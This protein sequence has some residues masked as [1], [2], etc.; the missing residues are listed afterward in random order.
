M[1]F[2]HRT[3]AAVVGRREGHE[4][5]DGRRALAEHRRDFADGRDAWGGTGDGTMNTDVSGR[6]SP[7]SVSDADAQGSASGLQKVRWQWEHRTGFRD[8]SVANSE[9]IEEAYQRGDT[10]VHLKSGKRNGIPMELFLLDMLQHDPTTGNTRPIQRVGPKGFLH[11]LRLR[12]AQVIRRLETGKAPQRFEGKQRSQSRRESEPPPQKV[13]CVQRLCGKI[14]RSQ[15]FSIASMLVVLFNACWI[16]VDV[17]LNDKPLLLQADVPFQVAENLFCVAFTME[18]LVR[19]GAFRRRQDLFADYWFLLDATLVVMMIAETWAL[20]LYMLLRGSDGFDDFGQF[21][22]LRVVRLLRLPRLARLFRFFPELGTL[23]KGILHAM[24]SVAYTMIMLLTVIFVFGVIF[25]VQAEMSPNL[26]GLFPT[27]A[28]TMTVLLL[29]GTL[30]D[31]PGAVYDKIASDSPLLAGLFLLFIFLS[32]FTVLN[33]LIGILCEVVSSVSH[34]EKEDA[35]VDYLKTHLVE[36]FEC[37][38]MDDDRLLESKEFDL[39]ARNPDFRMVLARFGVNANDVI[40]LRDFLFADKCTND[41][42]D[43]SDELDLSLEFMNTKKKLSFDEIM[44]AILRLRGGN[45]AT[46]S[47]IVE[48]RMYVARCFE[49]LT[50][51]LP[52]KAATLRKSPR[53]G[54]HDGQE[55][56]IPPELQVTAFPSDLR[57]QKPVDQTVA[58]ALKQ[59]PPRGREAVA[60]KTNSVTDELLLTL[61]PG[62][63]GAERVSSSPPW[64]GESGPQQ[65]CLDAARLPPALAGAPPP[66]WEPLPPC[67]RHEASVP[68]GMAAAKVGV[69]APMH[70][71]SP[72]DFLA[73]SAA[74]LGPPMAESGEVTPQAGELR[75]EGPLEAPLEVTGCSEPCSPCSA[76]ARPAAQTGQCGDHASIELIGAR[77]P[78]EVDASAAQETDEPHEFFVTPTAPGVG[79][80]IALH[81]KMLVGMLQIYVEPFLHCGDEAVERVLDLDASGQS[82]VATASAESAA[83]SAL[84][85]GFSDCGSHKIVISVGAPRYE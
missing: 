57:A 62:S 33:M 15:C 73:A 1:A 24:R 3:V 17:E 28:R 48:L 10:L 25:K 78:P 46:V 58:D 80:K 61:P 79:A 60:L 45:L 26:Q 55:T 42:D 85:S 69:S 34:A 84:A 40:A 68:L 77:P 7:V 53:G 30:L 27:L 20:P 18:I 14:V 16:G 51:G 22:A 41:D 37:Y 82:P 13:T 54:F 31:G 44:E 5:S 47:D 52:D 35:A 72:T 36:I 43:E 32:S 59:S 76:V 74:K 83:G 29:Q 9:R 21:A 8:Y 11:R 56:G 4:H 75:P 2:L 66:A 49:R 63:I 50:N 38:D 81:S 70:P 23:T 39:L 71:E 19:L 6:L 64:P 12:V 65:L 67:D